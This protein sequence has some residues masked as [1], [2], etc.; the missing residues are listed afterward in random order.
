MSSLLNQTTGE[1]ISGVCQSLEM[2]IGISAVFLL[3]VA[4]ILAIVF[5]VTIIF[6]YLNTKQ[7][8]KKIWQQ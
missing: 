7:E 8:E 1:C 4:I 2:F 6:Y 5:I 3:G